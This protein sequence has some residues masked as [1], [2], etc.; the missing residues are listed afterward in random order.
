MLTGT[1]EGFGLRISDLERVGVMIA[2]EQ[3]LRKATARK[4]PKGSTLAS[5]HPSVESQLAQQCKI[6]QGLGFRVALVGS[7][8][9]NIRLCSVHRSLNPEH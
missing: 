6:S 3:P 2:A 8:N 5:L 9:M 7:N 1:A 4:D